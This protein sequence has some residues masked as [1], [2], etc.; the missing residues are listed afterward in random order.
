MFTSFTG[1][2]DDIC[3]IILI[4]TLKD[5]DLAE[6]LTNLANT[7]KLVGLCRVHKVQLQGILDSW[8]NQGNTKC[9]GNYCSEL[10][11]ES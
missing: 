4:F 3:H 1:Y 7:P 2:S 6:N 5:Q 11:K 9:Q 10:S 8:W